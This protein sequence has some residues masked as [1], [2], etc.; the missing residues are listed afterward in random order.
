MENN[1]STWF[2]GLVLPAFPVVKYQR[3]R[4]EA[5]VGVGGCS[6]AGGVVTQALPIPCPS[7]AKIFN[8]L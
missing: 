6:S 2:Y 1:V 4:L 7:F 3:R 5:A 8:I